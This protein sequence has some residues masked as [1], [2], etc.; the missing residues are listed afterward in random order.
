[1]QRPL[2]FRV[3]DKLAKHFFYPD[4]GYQGHFILSLDG[5][6]HNLH[7]G[8]GGDEFIVQQYIGINDINGKDIYDGDV[9]EFDEREIGGYKGVAE[10]IYDTDMTLYGP[11]FQIFVLRAEPINRSGVAP[12]P[13]NCKVI[14]NIFE[15]S[16]LCKNTV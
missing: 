1:M 2:K 11:S 4:K 10:V 6:F 12:F 16:E 3:W 14:G 8:S 15:N 7:N 9:I 5:K 13:F